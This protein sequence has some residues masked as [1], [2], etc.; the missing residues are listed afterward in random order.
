MR[1][2]ITAT[3]LTFV[4]G[5][6]CLAMLG[7]GAIAFIYLSFHEVPAA[8][9]IPYFVIRQRTAISALAMT[10]AISCVIMGFA[11]FM[12]GAKGEFNFKAETS[13]GKGALAAGVPGPFFVLC[14]T[15][16]AITVLLARVSHEEFQPGGDAHA[17]A[18]DASA[19]SSPG[20]PVTALKSRTIAS[21]SPS[22]QQIALYTPETPAYNALVAVAVEDQ[23][24]Q[25]DQAIK[26]LASHHD[27]LSVVY[28]DFDNDKRELRT[29]EGVYLDDRNRQVTVSDGY[30]FVLERNGAAESVKAL[31]DAAGQVT[32]YF[33][34]PD[35][36]PPDRVSR[37]LKAALSGKTVFLHGEK[38]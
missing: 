30:L 12:I 15:A 1:P 37:I 36:L 4:L 28:V 9:S 14:G 27:D 5:I 34:P 33:P 29:F 22:P 8:P 3:K 25:I 13:W 38:P 16:I 18:I 31:L 20:K 23:P 10:T 7:Y 26:Y 19:S 11:V 17:A 32:A 6:F 24:E 21:S 2:K 35:Q